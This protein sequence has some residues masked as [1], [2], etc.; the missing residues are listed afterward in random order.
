MLKIVA[1]NKIPFLEGALEE[2]AHVTYIPGALISRQHLMDADALITRTRTRC[3]KTLLEETAV[4]M[5]ASATIG[6]DH[7]DTSYC[8]SKGIYWTNAPGCNAGSVQQYIASALAIITNRTARSY[9]ETTLGI[10][11]AGNVG[12]KVESM[13]K[14][15][16]MKV[17]VNDPPLQAEGKAGDFCNLERLLEEADIVSMHVPLTMQGRFATYH[18]ADQ[19]FFH[20]MKKDAWFI[21][22]SRGEVHDTKALTVALESGHLQGAVIDVW[23]NEPIVD[24]KLLDYALIATP[25]IAGYSADGKANGTAMCIQA[26]SRFFNVG[27]HCWYPATIP[28]VDPITLELDGYSCSKII[29]KLNLEAYNIAADS[30]R[31]KTSPQSFELLRE[32]YPI[33]R[34]PQALKVILKGYNSSYNQQ[35]VVSVIHSL[36]YNIIKE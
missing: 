14:I 25:H 22:S 6:Y 33:R 26:I 20:K 19:S 13:A 3:N 5:I 24:Q 11:G 30:M 31:L 34:E 35:N 27:P 15:L 17:L 28:A 16:G 23:E 2:F 8:D 32:T 4:K 18:M 1:D 12:S 10:V 36:G 29:N 9:C 7:I 21:N